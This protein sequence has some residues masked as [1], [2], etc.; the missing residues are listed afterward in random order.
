MTFDANLNPVHRVLRERLEFI[1]IYDI[2]SLGNSINCIVDEWPVQVFRFILE[3]VF[4]VVFVSYYII[5]YFG[6]AG[7]RTHSSCCYG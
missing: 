2:I 4:R 3:R 6:C 1:L 5:F 7:D